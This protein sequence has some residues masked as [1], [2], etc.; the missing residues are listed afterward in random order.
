MSDPD[1]VE[2]WL[3]HSFAQ[4][5]TPP[6]FLVWRDLPPRRNP[7][8][9]SAR[10]LMVGPGFRGVGLLDWHAACPTRRTAWADGVIR[11]SFGSE[12]LT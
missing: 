3:T 2:R 9:N 1:V 11:R 8:R 6:G 7:M 5:E 12:S 4:V 10:K